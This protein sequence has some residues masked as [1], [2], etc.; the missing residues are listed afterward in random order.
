VQFVTAPV[1]H[2][3]LQSALRINLLWMKKLVIKDWRRHA[4]DC[5]QLHFFDDHIGVAR[6]VEFD[7]EDIAHALIF[8]HGQAGKRK[9][10]L[11]KNGMVLC[12]VGQ[13]TVPSSPS[14]RAQHFDP[15]TTGE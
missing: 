7:A 14:S 13:I 15:T 1:P 9:A 5:F 8:A 2:Q 12:T 6:I 10:E 4:V 3:E 11:R